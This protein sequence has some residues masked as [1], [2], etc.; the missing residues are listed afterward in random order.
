MKVDKLFK[1]LHLICSKD[2]SRRTL[3]FIKIDE[4]EKLGQVAVATDGRRLICVPVEAEHYEKD[5]LIFGDL[6]KRAM[7]VKSRFGK[8][9]PFT[10]FFKN[11]ASRVEV[12]DVSKEN[13][14]NSTPPIE[15]Y[16]Q[17]KCDGTYPNWQQVVPVLD[18][19]AH[20]VTFDPK[21]LWEL[22]QAMGLGGDKEGITIGFQDKV[23]PMVVIPSQKRDERE[24]FGVL[25]PLLNEKGLD[26]YPFYKVDKEEP[27]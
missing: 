25:M 5:R 11:Y 9:M 3:Q 1:K 8:K 20:F 6:W 15:T 23:S 24:A 19:D 14:V 13:V 16:R 10:P 27:K 26:D 18:K 7:L 17:E 2:E 21:L 22:A 4:T 12:Y